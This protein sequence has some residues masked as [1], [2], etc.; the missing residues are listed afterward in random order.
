MV[1]AYPY[2]YLYRVFLQH[3]Q[4]S[5]T[6][7]FL[8][9]FG[10]ATVSSSLIFP[11]YCYLCL[12]HSSQLRDNTLRSKWNVLRLS[13]SFLASPKIFVWPLPFVFLKNWPWSGFDATS[14]AFSSY[15]G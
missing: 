5:F 3:P 4:Q 2:V 8:L 13:D 10:I 14:F 11:W 7:S 12:N 15:K 6:A 1:I 9:G